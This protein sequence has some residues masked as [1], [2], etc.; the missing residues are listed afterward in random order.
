MEEENSPIKVHS[1]AK[2]D[3]DSLSV[4]DWYLEFENSETIPWK[5]TI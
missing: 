5:S 3:Q 4:S 2:K 1:T